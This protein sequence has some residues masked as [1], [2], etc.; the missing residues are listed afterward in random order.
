MNKKKIDENN[1]R[2]AI[3]LAAIDKVVQDNIVKPTEKEINGKDFISFG[4]RNIYPQYLDG[5]YKGCT[6]L[7]TIVN[8]LTDYVV[9]DDVV[10]SYTPWENQVNSKGENMEDI[11]R[12]MAMSYAIYGGFYLNVV[13]NKIGGIA[14]IYV[15]DFKKV[16]TNKENTM[17]YYSEDW[18]TSY[19]RV[20]YTVYPKFDAEK[21]DVSSIYYYK[22]T[23]YNVYPEALYSASAIYCEIE[24]LIGEY[25]L[26]NIENG[27]ASTVIL[28]LNNGVPTDEVKEEIERD[29]EEKFCG[30]DN[31]G[32][33][34]ITYS[35]ARDNAPTVQQLNINDFSEKYK[36]LTERCNQQIHAAFSM[37]PVL[38]GNV[39][40]NGTFNS[41]DFNEAFKLFNK[42]VVKPIQKVICNSMK[43]IMGQEIIT[44]S[45][46]NIDWTDDEKK[47]IVD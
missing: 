22:N 23:Y 2:V 41:E 39:I 9:G 21:K 33:I 6:T 25:H 20:K 3:S 19:G 37:H 13:R 34:M 12:Q 44:I 26:N 7:K 30:S 28:G 8:R 32:R 4:D 5:L 47:E 16:R 17:F 11:V 43:K 1:G 31:A 46:F 10:C 15:L 24:K 29:I 27:F 38:V 42:T 35:N 14:E 40:N 36:T 45:Q 18:G